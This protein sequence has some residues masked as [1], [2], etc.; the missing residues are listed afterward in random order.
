MLRAAVSYPLSFPEVST[1]LLGAKTAAQ[2][3]TNFGQLPGT[4]AT[5]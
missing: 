1:V 5:A 3:E 2:A 4:G